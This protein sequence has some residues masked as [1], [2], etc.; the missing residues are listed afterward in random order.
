MVN[1]LRLYIVSCWIKAEDVCVMPVRER[2]THW[3]SLIV[4][5]ERLQVIDVGG[6]PCRFTNVIP[7]VD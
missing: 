3:M 7:Q 6:L 5:C 4:T 2:P 1:L